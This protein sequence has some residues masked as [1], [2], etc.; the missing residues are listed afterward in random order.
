M[1]PPAE[2]VDRLAVTAP[3]PS[4]IVSPSHPPEKVSSVSSAIL[5]VPSF[6]TGSGPP[7][8]PPRR[9]TGRVVA[10]AGIAVAILGI[11][12]IGGVW[13]VARLNPPPTT[14]PAGSPPPPTP[15]ETQP[16][17]TSAAPPVDP[18]KPSATVTAEP[19]PSAHPITP[20]IKAAGGKRP[21]PV[22]VKPSATTAPTTPD[23]LSKNPY[24]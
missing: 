11:G 22:P 9:S 2:I 20:T 10:M 15:A 12:V 5:Q 6:E 23:D 4:G 3:A 18:P 7:L 19:A 8:V 14:A 17:P 24:R 13:G 21:A 1:P 16:P